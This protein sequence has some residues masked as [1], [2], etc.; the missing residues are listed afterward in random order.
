M[1]K[2]SIHPPYLLLPKLQKRAVP[3][4][5][6]LFQAHSELSIKP[7]AAFWTVWD[8]GPSDTSLAELERCMVVLGKAFCQLINAGQGKVKVSQK[9]SPQDLVTEVDKGIEMLLRLWIKR[10]YPHHKIIGE[11]GYKESFK[12]SD[13]VWYIDPVDGTSNFV[14]GNERVAMHVACIGEGKPLFSMV[15]LPMQDKLFYTQQETAYVWG[16]H[17]QASPQ[18]VVSADWNA[19]VAL[20]TEYMSIRKT[21]AA[22]A[23]RLTKKL[24]FPHYRVKS[25]GI[26]LMDML[27]KK[28]SLFYR[29]RIKLWDVMAPM[30]ILYYAAQGHLC[31][32]LG[33]PW[34]GTI[35]T[36]QNLRWVSP[37]SHEDTVV[38][39]LNNRHK[40]NSR[41][42]LILVYPASHPSLKT[43][44]S[45]AVL[46]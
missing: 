23:K 13:W 16:Y 21:D 15:G 27:A 11:E 2:I 32:E 6:K 4:P 35:L 37:F 14:E 43:I 3:N 25:I 18:K 46:G 1:K 36:K 17:T 39:W 10:F 28:V 26:N 34:E 44:L 40:F 7:D 5:D 38:H 22:L 42:G 9:T 29:N 33:I 45:D 8:Q 19:L 31:F 30:G 41:V 24:G 12:S 20:G